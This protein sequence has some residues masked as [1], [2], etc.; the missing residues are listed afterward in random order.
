[1]VCN[2]K[3]DFPLTPSSVV[4]MV[5]KPLTLGYKKP[6]VHVSSTSPRHRTGA[7][8]SIQCS[9][10][11]LSL[12]PDYHVLRSLCEP[13]SRT[14]RTKALGKPD[15]LRVHKTPTDGFGGSVTNSV[16]TF[17]AGRVLSDVGAFSWTGLWRVL[18]GRTPIPAE[19]GFQTCVTSGSFCSKGT[20]G[21]QDWQGAFP[22]GL[23]TTKV[24]ENQSFKLLFRCYDSKAI[25]FCLYWSWNSWLSNTLKPYVIAWYSWCEMR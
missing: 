13:S 25:H 15:L 14:A 23:F 6:M 9:S 2:L 22:P 4:R 5:I 18:C 24:S 21:L 12:P 1:M 17:F 10:F 7:S 8:L 16:V 11:I 20:L 19:V 3:R